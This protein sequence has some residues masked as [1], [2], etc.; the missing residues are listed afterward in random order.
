MRAE[1]GKEKGMVTSDRS[2]CRTGTK[3]DRR[4]GADV[5]G[6]SRPPSLLPIRQAHMLNCSA[7]LTK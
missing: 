2:K 3:R 4:E 7:W 6:F 1:K 5:A